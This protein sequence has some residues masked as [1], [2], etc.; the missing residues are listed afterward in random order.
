MNIGIDARPLSYNLTGIG[1]YLKNTLDALQSIDD[2]NNYY[3]VSNKIINYQL[4]ND[5]W[6]K[7]EGRFGYSSVSSP[8]MQFMAPRIA[9][10]CKFD[11]FWGTRHHLPLFLPFQVKRLVTIHDLVHLKHPETMLKKNLIL[12]RILMNRSL[13][14]ADAIISISHATAADILK[15]YPDVSRE[16]IYTVYP[17]VPKLKRKKASCAIVE[18]LPHNYFLFVGTMEPRKNLHN[19]LRAF[20]RL[21]PEN[22]DVHLVIAGG[23]GWKDKELK[24][25]F[26]NYKFA[27]RIVFTG[28]VPREIMISLYK[29]AACLIFPS[30][31]E[32]FGFPII[33][34]MSCGIPVITS[35]R[36]S[37]KEIA[38][39]AALLVNPYDIASIEGAMKLILTDKDLKK[40]LIEKAA[41]RLKIFS[42]DRC[43]RESMAIFDKVMKH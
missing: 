1:Y 7:I 22:Y 18:Q 2:V 11:V 3:L 31:Y 43:A 8:W 37:M 5:K 39:D 33:E 35:D 36:S 17:G 15:Y 23:R 24:I 14:T 34:A 29:K 26:D 12:E 41:L 30:L 38:S 21:N 19:L 20:E 42:W 4:V 32:G 40:K 9:Y 10:K 28:Y 27:S 16:N 6:Q 13:A 25:F